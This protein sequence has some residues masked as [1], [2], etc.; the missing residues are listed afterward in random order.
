[1]GE[2]FIDMNWTLSLPTMY[3]DRGLT[4]LDNPNSRVEG[5]GLYGGTQTN[6][7]STFNVNVQISISIHP[8]V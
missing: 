5:V 7:G 8:E 1:M 3:I 2:H 6:G 4:N